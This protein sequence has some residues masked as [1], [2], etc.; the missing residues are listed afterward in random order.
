MNNTLNS[1]IL[2][3]NNLVQFEL[4]PELEKLFTIMPKL[5]KLIHILDWVEIE[6][7]IPS[8]AH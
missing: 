8:T 2:Q 6:Q 3:R 1:E 5:Q 7:F 4:I